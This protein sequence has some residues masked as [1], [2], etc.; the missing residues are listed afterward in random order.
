[1]KFQVPH[2]NDG[3]GDGDDDDDDDDEVLWD[4]NQSAYW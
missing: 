4:L 2:S 3:D 1:V